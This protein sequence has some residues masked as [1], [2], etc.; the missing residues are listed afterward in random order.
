MN[1]KKILLTR[2]FP[3]IGAEML[4]EA[5]FSVTVWPE[6]QPMAQDELIEQA[7]N[8]NAL[9]CTVTEKI[10]QKFLNACSH[11]DIISQF[12]VGFDNINVAEATKLGIAIS[13][14]PNAMAE[15]TADTAFG[16][17]I[18]ASRKMF[19]MHKQILK[20]EW[21]YFKPKT[22]LGQ[23]LNNKTLGIYGMGKIGMAMAKRCKGAYNMKIIYCDPIPNTKANEELQATYVDFKTLLSESD[24][25]TLH[26]PLTAE[27]KGLFNKEAFLQM[28]TSSIFIN[29]ARGPIHNEQDLID[30]LKSGI[31][32]GAGLDVTNPEPINVD[33]PLLQME[34][35]AVLPHI[36]SATIKARHEMARSA[37]MNIIAFYKHNKARNIVNPEVMK[38]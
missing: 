7:K 6:D 23:E 34:N 35:V 17:M 27:T 22:N 20:G 21:G 9:Y 18:A 25:I 37:A 29:T 33:N 12:A 15:A 13:N 4:N 19:F 38:K 28:K 2:Q 32:W 31:I 36:G 3:E 16:L 8:H 26:C 14:T 10:D 5:G 1:D 11:L 24:V 30:A